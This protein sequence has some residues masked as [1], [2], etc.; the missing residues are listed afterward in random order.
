MSAW[1]TLPQLLSALCLWMPVGNE[2][3][4][5]PPQIELG[6]VRT[7]QSRRLSLWLCNPGPEPLAV[8]RLAGSCG[9]VRIADSPT[10]VP[11]R[12]RVAVPVEIHTLS[13]SPGNHLWTIQ[14]SLS[15]RDRP[16][17]AVAVIKATVIQEIVV[18]PPS[19][20]IIGSGPTQHEIRVTDLRGHPIR[21]LKAEAS[22]PHITVSEPQPSRDPLGRMVWT[23]AFSVAAGLPPGQYQETL[24]LHTDDPTHREL[25]IPVSVV[26]RGSAQRVVSSPE[27]LDLVVRPDQPEVKRTV[28]LRDQQGGPLVIDYVLTSDE[29]LRCRVTT[30]P[31]GTPAVEVSV[32]ASRMKTDR[33]LTRVVVHLS[34]PAGEKVVIPVRIL[35]Q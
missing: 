26:R 17:A 27:Q 1:L 23:L 16:L 34:Q 14:A 24:V 15:G 2:P 29:A 31:G 25:R 18:Q 7:G 12:G 3:Y 19:V 9:C 21:I 33:L 11:A 30:G 22:S 10:T 13:A 6:E 35:R 4:F 28:T 32:S 5:D 20:Q 8:T